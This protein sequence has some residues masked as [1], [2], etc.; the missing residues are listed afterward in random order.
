MSELP[1]GFV[2][3][4][5]KRTSL[6]DGFSVDAP[7]K[8]DDRG[9][10]DKL[11]GTTGERYQTWPERMVREALSLPQRTI[12]AATSEPA[13]SRAATEAMIP[14]ATETAAT[15]LPVNPAI[16]AGDKAIPGVVKALKPEKP[17]VPTTEELAKAGG[18]AINAAKSSGLDIRPE[19]I[20]DHSRKI[21]SELFDKGIHPVDAPNTYAKLRELEEAPANSVF[22]AANLQSLRESLGATA[23]NFNPSAAKDQLAATRA[24]KGFDQ[25]LPQLD[26]ASVLAGSPAA[27]QKLF[28]TGRGNYAAA[29]RSND[30]TGVLDRANTGILERAET[31]AKAVNS[32]RNLDNTI[33]SKVASILEKPKEISGLDDAEL[34]ALNRTIEGGGVRNSAREIGNLLGGGG[35][36]G[37]VVPGLMTGGSAAIAAGNPL[38]LGLGAIPPI[39][40]TT[41]RAVANALAKRDLRSADELMRSRSPLFRERVENPELAVIDPDKRAAVARALMMN[42]FAG[43]N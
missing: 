17:V 39:V 13:G 29:M 30:I 41:S 26:E 36:L 35:G 38:L 8:K 43:Q 40:G 6:P 1:D 21:Q 20:A 25:F 3:D 4:A 14:T 27:T 19:A 15:M 2:V 10:M 33:R 24:I 23:Q 9:V 22:S 7:G 28:E 5:P 11:L 32:G 12:D 37:A 42:Q 18:D 31:R 34:A 16:R